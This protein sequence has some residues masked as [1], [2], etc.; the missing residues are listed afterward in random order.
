MNPVEQVGLP[1]HWL[2]LFVSPAPA[3][4]VQH[5]VDAPEPVVISLAPQAWYLQHCGGLEDERIAG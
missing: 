1:Q 3:L 4:Q 5:C 2:P